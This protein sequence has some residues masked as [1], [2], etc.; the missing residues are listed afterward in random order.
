MGKEAQ[1][2]K[3]GRIN[4]KRAPPGKTRQLERLAAIEKFF[5]AVPVNFDKVRAAEARH[6]DILGHDMC[7]SREGD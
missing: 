1:L 3:A 6:G 2:V 4:R 7:W 5:K